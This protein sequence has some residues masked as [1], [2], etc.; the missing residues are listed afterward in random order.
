[1][2]G[3]FHRE[4]RELR[5]FAW[6]ASRTGWL[7]QVRPDKQPSIDTLVGEVKRARVMSGSEIAHAMQ[8]WAAAM[9]GR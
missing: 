7:A 6:L 9:K 2:R 5:R 1:M 4:K 8:A 3:A